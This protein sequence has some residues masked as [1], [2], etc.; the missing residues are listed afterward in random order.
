LEFLELQE[1]LLLFII[2]PF[3]LLFFFSVILG[4]ELR[5]LALARQELYDLKHMGFF[6]IGS[7]KIEPP[8][9]TLSNWFCF[10]MGLG[11]EL[12]SSGLQSRLSI[13]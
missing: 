12:R 6:K 2:S 9:P 8:A 1:C 10:L 11:F 3:I 5:D 7:S 13:T 4:F